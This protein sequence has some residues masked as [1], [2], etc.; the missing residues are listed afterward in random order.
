MRV[1]RGLG[2]LLS[3]FD[4]HVFLFVSQCKLRNACAYFESSF[5]EKIGCMCL[6]NNKLIFQIKLLR[7]TK[8]LDLTLSYSLKIV[9]PLHNISFL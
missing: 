8:F 6:L 4:L 7:E 2:V 9:L 1:T 3:I 5:Y